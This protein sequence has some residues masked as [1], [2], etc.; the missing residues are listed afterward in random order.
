MVKALGLTEE[1]PLILPDLS[2]VDGGGMQHVAVKCVDMLQNTNCEGS[3][4]ARY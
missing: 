1:L 3:S 4:R 2:A